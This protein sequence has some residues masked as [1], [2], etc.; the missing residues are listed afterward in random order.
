MHVDAMG[1]VHKPVGELHAASQRDKSIATSLCHSMEL[2]VVHLSWNSRTS[3]YTM[4]DALTEKLTDRYNRE[5]HTYRDLWSPILRTAGLRLLP[6]LADTPVQRIVDVGTGVGS[7]LP[8]LRESFPGAFVLGVDRAKGM[9]ELAPRG[10]PL[11]VMDARQLALPPA[12]VDLVL[13]TFMLF[14]LEKPE[15]GLREAR[16]VLRHG[17]RVG[18]VTWGGELESNAT[19]IWTECLDAHGAVTADPAT[20]TRHASVDTPEKMETLLRNSGFT[21]PHSWADDLVSTLDLEH[22]LR[23]RTSMGSAKPRFDSLDPLTREA[24][25][26]NARHRMEGLACEDFVARGR[27]VYAVAST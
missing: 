11:A 4:Q 23:L 2:A 25:M 7:L 16:R 6:E 24:C 15:D 21:S 22:L 13:L 3:G 9:L 12:S 18:T 1:V 20:E 26:A 14:H 19:R 8:D 27:I 17:G 10:V 5:A